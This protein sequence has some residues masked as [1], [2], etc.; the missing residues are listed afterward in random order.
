MS[1]G[2][3]CMESRES[4][5]HIPSATPYGFDDLMRDMLAEG[6]AVNVFVHT[7]RWIDI[8]RIEDLRKA[9]EQAQRIRLKPGEHDDD[10]TA[11]DAALIELGAPSLGDAEKRALCRGDRRRLAHDG[12]ARPRFEEPFAAMHGASDAVAVNSATAA[13]HLSLQ[14]SMSGRET[15]CW[16]RRSPSWRRPTWSSTAVP[17]RCSST[18]R[19][20]QPAPVDRRCAAPD[21][22]AHQGVMLMHY[23]GFV[24]DVRRGGVCRRH[25]L[26]LLEDAAHTAGMPGRAL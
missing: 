9:Q 5:I 25:G 26:L 8:G 1:T 12:R 11:Q 4:S 6:R 7:G 23:G 10:A 14:C 20:A 22:S 16:C 3:Y 2:I 13:L 21:H 15:K 17:R 24:I 18:S 19:R